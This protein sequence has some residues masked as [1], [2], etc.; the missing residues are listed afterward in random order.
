[1][2]NMIEI[3][4]TGIEKVIEMAGSQVALAKQLGVRQQAI[5]NWLKDGYVPYSRLVEIE[6]QYGVPRLDLVNPKIRELFK[7][8]PFENVE[9]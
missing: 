4:K 9:E 2:E 3:N 8:I 6:A 1:M 5:H 7:D